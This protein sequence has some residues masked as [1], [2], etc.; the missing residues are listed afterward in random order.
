LN[1]LGGW[2]QSWFNYCWA[3]G[4]A[5]Q[6]KLEKPLILFKLPRDIEEFWQKMKIHGWAKAE[7]IGLG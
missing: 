4:G 6:G 2:G 3:G 5:I 1:I 7:N